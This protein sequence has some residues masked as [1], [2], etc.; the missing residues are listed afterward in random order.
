MTDG[1]SDH[2]E[3]TAEQLAALY[4]QQQRTA[5]PVQRAVNRVTA[6]L[7][8]PVALSIVTLLILGW[9]AGNYALRAA[10]WQAL[11]EFPFPDLALVATIVAL[12]VALLILTTQ[13]HED[14]LAE[15]RARLTLHIA[16]LSEKKIAKVIELLEEQRRDNPLLPSRA[17]AEAAAMAQ[18]SDPRASA[19]RL[20]ESTRAAMATE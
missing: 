8:R 2:V 17:D 11:E 9:A 3:H 1:E 6:A 14:E 10:G 15:R 12:L 13:R 7:G 16:V 20:E 18:A 19:E 4:D 5:S